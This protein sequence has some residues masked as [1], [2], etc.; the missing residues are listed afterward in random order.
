[1][2]LMRKI[3]I[4]PPQAEIYR[5][6][7]LNVFATTD[8]WPPDSSQSSSIKA[9]TGSGSQF[10]ER[11]HEAGSSTIFPPVTGARH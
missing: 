10:R 9:A 3:G 8:L 4:P 2:P 1:M 11:P 5:V 6:H 7:N